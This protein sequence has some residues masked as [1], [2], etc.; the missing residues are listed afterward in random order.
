MSGPFSQK[1]FL[2]K[3]RSIGSTETANHYMQARQDSP[4]GYVE[5][6]LPW[7][8][9]AAGLVVY[10]ITLNHWVT[11]A[12]LPLVSKVTGWDWW[13]I[14]LQGPLFLALTVP[15]RW[16]PSAWQ[17]LC[18]NLFSA[19]CAAAA[20]GLLARSVT[21]LPHDRTRDQRQRER[22]EYSQLSIA[23]AWLPPVLAALALGLQ[24][25]WWEHAT[26]ATGETLNLLVF[27]Y[28]IRCLLEYRL[29]PRESWL[30]KLAF[31]YGLGV[32][33]NFAM[34]PFLPVL[35]LALIWMNLS[36]GF[37]FFLSPLPLRLAGWG[38]L[39]LTLYLLLPFLEA[40]SGRTPSTFWELLRLEMV[41]QKNVLVAFPRYLVVLCGL[42]SLLPVL[43]MGI[44]WKSSIGDTSV[45]GGMLTHLMFRVVH[46]ILLAV[47]LWVMFDPPFSPRRRGFGMP[48]LTFYYLTGLAIGY[49]SGYFLLVFGTQP[50]KRH[51]Q[52]SGISRLIEQALAGL[53]WLAL[54]AI[55][56][57]LIYQNWPKI[58]ANNGPFLQRM[59]ANLAGSLPSTSAIVMSDE[60]IPLLL[61]EAALHTDATG[62]RHVT[63]DSRYLTYPFYHRSLLRHFPNQWP[64]V[65]S[66]IQDSESLGEMDL[67]VA[68]TG[69]ARTNQL[70]FLNPTFSYPAEGLYAI[71]T[72]LAFLMKP[73]PKLVVTN[74]PLSADQI[75]NNMAFWARTKA[76]LT[77]LPRPGRR[78]EHDLTFSD[79]DYVARFYSRAANYLGVRLQ[80]SGNLNEAGQ[81][82]ELALDLN[83][84]NDMAAI[85]RDFNRILRTGPVKPV[86]LSQAMEDRLKQKYRR[87]EDWLQENGPVDEL[88][89]C[90]QLG[91][92]MAFAD[93]LTR[94]AAQ[95]FT[96]VQELDPSNFDARIWLGNLFLK[97]HWPDKTLEVVAAMKALPQ[98]QS[99]ENQI[100]MVQLE[101]WAYAF[102]TNVP[103]A[104]ELLRQAQQKNPGVAGLA[105]T[106]S[107]IYVQM[108]QFSNALV[109]VDQQLRIDPN[110][111][112]ALLN[113]GALCIELK[114][115]TNAVAALNH[116][117]Q[118]EPKNDVARMNRAI[119]L[120]QSGQLEDAERDYAVL[121]EQNPHFYKSYFGLGQI[122]MARQNT[123]A[124]IGNFELY[125][126][127]VPRLPNNAPRDP[128]EAEYVSN[129]LSVLRG[130][131]PAR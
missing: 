9:A 47:C 76:D 88:R 116:V 41:F 7:I 51:H 70:Y 97:S 64:K 107:Q 23:A 55:P 25:T 67:L 99:I 127:Y 126:K 54:L 4:T 112:K 18:L 95:Q 77:A 111:P 121:L 98:S 32:A 27:A 33:N 106:L 73:Y 36:K 91:T 122:A 49:Y 72:G 45:V 108:R 31:V 84:E 26:A 75:S 130:S 90:N 52:A 37:G 60:P 79:S 46:V 101:A 1:D 38:L 105:E 125:L 63:V 58:R 81:C 71:P 92:N 15:I 44:R 22:S 39:G 69:M 74:P 78:S 109:A 3:R 24:L 11:V 30:A 13:S 120:L 19:A 113:K 50:Q 118:A 65:R 124:A 100:E 96:R 12:S 16:L 40:Q 62:P 115:Y 103:K 10:L 86:E 21:L 29:D 128:A 93:N 57:G 5:S 87:W 104:T 89:F 114:D 131:K 14:T 43:V 102:K 61:V 17:P 48:F 28:V 82:F 80:R 123:A 85:N 2:A 83:P 53:V 8:V 35:V 129:R 119:A 68:L 66:G 94:Q 34:I 110:N 117:L 56:A 42:T 6:I 59:A 20:L